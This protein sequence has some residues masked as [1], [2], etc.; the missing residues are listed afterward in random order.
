MLAVLTALNVSTNRMLK[1]R[2]H[3]LPFDR[4]AYLGTWCEKSLLNQHDL[5]PIH[6]FMKASGKL[7][8]ITVH[9]SPNI[10]ILIWPHII[11][12][13]LYPIEPMT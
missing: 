5:F 1:V 3:M 7:V 12:M 8:G 11:L 9:L 13:S 10:E 2:G 4:Q 6:A